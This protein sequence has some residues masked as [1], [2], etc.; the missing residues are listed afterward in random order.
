MQDVPCQ[1]V[2]LRFSS[3]GT[4]PSSAVAVERCSRGGFSFE[5]M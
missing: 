1:R 3:G 5:L 4:S 2:Q